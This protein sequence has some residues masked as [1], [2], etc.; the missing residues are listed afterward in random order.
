[1]ASIRQI[2]PTDIDGF[3]DLFE[4]IFG[5]DWC[6]REW[7]RWKYDQFS[8]LNDVSVVVARDD[9]TIVGAIGYF[10]IELAA[11]GGSVMGVQ[12]LDVMIHPDFRGQ[13]TFLQMVRE[14]RKIFYPDNYIEFGW[15]NIDTVDIWTRLQQWEILHQ[16]NPQYRCQHFRDFLSSSSLSGLEDHLISLSA[17]PYYIWLT[18]RDHR[19]LPDVN[20]FDVTRY[21][22]PPVDI[23]SDM[24]HRSVPDDIHAV[25]DTAFYEARLGNPLNT[26]FTYVA[27]KEGDPIASLI[28]SEFTYDDIPVIADVLPLNSSAQRSTGLRAILSHVIQDYPYAPAIEASSALPEAVLEDFGFRSSTNIGA[29][30]ERQLDESQLS[31]VVPGYDPKTFCVRSAPDRPL[32]IDHTAY[33]NWHLTGI[34]KDT[35]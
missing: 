32:S 26:Y 25:R 33:E 27:R 35:V 11:D 19:R 16:D 22:D 30:L 15:P 3:L 12:P 18:I 23:L 31:T 21:G 9:D 7:F 24:Y 1:M 5:Y 20:D 4:T 13:N 8:A 6:T 17:L 14:G 2:Q 10:G 29:V 28:V 34:E